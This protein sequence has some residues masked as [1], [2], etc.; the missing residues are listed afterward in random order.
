MCHQSCLNFIINNINNLDIH[1]KKILEIGSSNVNGSARDI[2]I[3]FNPSEYIGCDIVPN[4]RY[5]DILCDAENIIDKFGYKV[6]DIVI[7]TEVLEHIFNWKKVIHNIKN[8]LTNNGIVVIT[9][10]SKGFHRHNYPNDYWRYEINDMKNIF[11]DFDIIV[12]ESDKEVPGVFL[13]AQKS[14]S[15]IENDLINYNINQI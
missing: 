13:I 11:S 12:L 6:F 7:A 2:I 15:F 5:V 10:R 1:N 4:N 3:K 14:I 8:I 9:T